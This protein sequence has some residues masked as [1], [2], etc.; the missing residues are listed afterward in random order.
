M[1]FSLWWNRGESN[2]RPEKC[3]SALIPVETL[4]GPMFLL[5]LLF[6]SRVSDKNP[7]RSSKKAFFALLPFATY[8]RNALPGTRAA[9]SEFLSPR[10]FAWRGV[11]ARREGA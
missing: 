1:V 2:P 11:S 3:A 8:R 10:G 6:I 9:V 5:F 4:R 7:V